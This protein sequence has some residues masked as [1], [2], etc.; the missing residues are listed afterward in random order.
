[1]TGENLAVH[2]KDIFNRQW[3]S[4]WPAR[5]GV[6]NQKTTLNADKVTKTSYQL[7]TK[8]CYDFYAWY[9]F[10]WQSYYVTHNL[11]TSN[12]STIFFNFL[13]DSQ[14]WQPICKEKH[15]QFFSSKLCDHHLER[16]TYSQPACVLTLL[17]LNHIIKHMLCYSC[18]SYTYIS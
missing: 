6:R 9:F 8:T 18:S 10:C 13:T 3:L 17:N 1:M 12:K 5:C 14:S 7:V 11:N 2:S 4:K 15:P 16:I